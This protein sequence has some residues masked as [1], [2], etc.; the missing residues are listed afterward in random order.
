MRS[1][2]QKRQYQH[3]YYLAHR[4][5][6]RESRKRAAL[7]RQHRR[8]LANELKKE[9]KKDGFRATT[10]RRFSAHGLTRKQ[11]DQLLA[12]QGG[13]CA[14]CHQLKKLVI[15]H[16]H[17][18][19]VVRG[20]LCCRCNHMLGMLR[21]DPGVFR[22][23]AA[24]MDAEVG[25]LRSFAGASYDLQWGS[26]SNLQ[27]ARE[28]L[29]WQRRF[30]ERGV[31]LSAYLALQSHQGGACAVCRF[32]PGARTLE[33][34]VHAGRVLGLVCAKCAHGMT[35][36]DWNQECLLAAAAYLEQGSSIDET[37]LCYPALG[38]RA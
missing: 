31:S 33:V 30:R 28:V 37:T 17:A 36:S 15:D 13:S 14:I 7:E 11:Y 16:N 35:L 38:A 23:A 19:G 6:L 4:E 3:E 9:I 5:R 1:S 27:K 29:K 12:E 21:D 22:Q 20:L 18:T 32:H 34:S 26:M 25:D 2:E 8:H 24:F 10:S